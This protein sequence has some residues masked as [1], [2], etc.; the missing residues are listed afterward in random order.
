MIEYELIGG[1]VEEFEAT[2]YSVLSNSYGFLS[3]K[4]DV[5]RVMLSNDEK[6]KQYLLRGSIAKEFLERI[7]NSDLNKYSF[8]ITFTLS[9]LTIG[10]KIKKIYAIKDI[11]KLKENQTVSDL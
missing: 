1:F 10:K 6:K 4:Y 8:K 5:V 9:S 11:I 2:R 7:A 3:N